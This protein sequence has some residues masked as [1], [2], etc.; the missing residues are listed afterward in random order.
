MG[1]ELWASDKA[2]GAAPALRGAWYAAAPD[3]RFNQL[4]TRYRTH[5]GKSPYRL[6]SLGYDA[7]LLAVRSA[8]NW[9]VGKPFPAKG[10]TD[11]GGFAG[12]DGS[13]RFGNVFD[14]AVRYISERRIDVRPLISSQHKI[15]DA[16]DASGTMDR[17]TFMR[18]AYVSDPLVQVMK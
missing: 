3:A 5:Y 11:K 16:I 4:S 15:T 13:F 8:R 17:A 1:T 14:W 9:P 2:L 12:V 7:G 10:L 6:A 18:H